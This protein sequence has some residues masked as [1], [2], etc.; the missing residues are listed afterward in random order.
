MDVSLPETAPVREIELSGNYPGIRFEPG[1]HIT[2][3]DQ[4]SQVLAQ[5]ALGNLNASLWN[6]EVAMRISQYSPV[7]LAIDG[8]SP[9][10]DTAHPVAYSP[11]YKKLLWTS[12]P[13]RPQ[14][15]NT[16]GQI[17]TISA[18]VTAYDNY[19]KP[20]ADTNTPEGERLS[21]RYEEVLRQI[22]TAARTKG[23]LGIIAG[24]LITGILIAGA[25]AAAGSAANELNSAREKT[26]PKISRRQFLHLTGVTTLGLLISLAQASTATASN[27]ESS[28]A[29]TEGGR[30]FWL[31]VIDIVRPRF[32]KSEWL[33][34]RT[35]LLIAKS[36]DAIDFLGLP[37]NTPTSVVMGVSHSYEANTL[38]ES[39]TERKRVISGWTT[40]LVNSL[41]DLLERE[42]L[43]HLKQPARDTLLN[44]VTSAE[45][46]NINDPQGPNFNPNFPRM[47]DYYVVPTGC[48]CSP[49]VEAAIH[50]LRI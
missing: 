48:F 17:Y 37:K 1:K 36:Q 45:V 20:L 14:R 26:R 25:T 2:S 15:L 24:P 18:D 7:I 38:M 43:M 6:P 30:Q 3:T 35:A 23:G 22:E 4:Y 31:D 8:Q 49:R 5:L 29:T 41:D 34:A 9:F 27:L 13:A 11:D 21:R 39:A 50:H 33:N 44:Y 40:S 47:I 10:S 28:T 46:F 32:I 42:G 19:L 16:A 12:M